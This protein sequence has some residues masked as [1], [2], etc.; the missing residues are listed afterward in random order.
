[1][2]I[3]FAI[4]V[5]VDRLVLARARHVA[6]RIGDRAVSRGAQ[7]RLQ[8]VRRLVFLV[9]LV[10]GAALALSQFAKLEKLA[11][12]I[13]ASSAVLGLVLGFAARQTIGNLVAGIM[14][15]I[16]Q[17]I[18][19]GDRITF[20]DQ[21]GRVDDITLSYTYID[22]GDGRLMVVPNERLAA[23]VVFNHSTGDQ[24]A[25]VAAS[26]WLPTDIDL[27]RARRALDAAGAER[28]TVEEVTPEGVRVELR[29]TPESARTRVGGEEAAL[30][31]RALGALREAGLLRDES[32]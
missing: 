5:A 14:L 8:L 6:E 32:A 26:V 10:I 7:T 2:A 18:R 1:M 29:T 3:A 16:A 11:A 21:T 31:E 19:I 30:R 15:A 22:P 27:D 4:A 20:E 23:G 13:L 12:G 24:S 9:I 28:V 25:P 17:P